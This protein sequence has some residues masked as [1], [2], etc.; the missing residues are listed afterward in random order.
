LS[1]TDHTL[2]NNS[3]AYYYADVTINNQR[4]ITA[5]IWYTRADDPLSVEWNAPSKS[6]ETLRIIS[7][8]ARGHLELELNAQQNSR[9]ILNIY[10]T[11]GQKVITETRQ[12]HKGGNSY[13]IP[14]SLSSGLYILEVITPQH[15]IRKTFSHL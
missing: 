3:S 4:T 5:P 10:N 12:A 7:N 6:A 9:A 15:N 2:L 11:A 14:L 1:F 13:S 8:P